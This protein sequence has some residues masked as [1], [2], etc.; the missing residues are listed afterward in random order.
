MA[1]GQPPPSQYPPSMGPGG[2]DRDDDLLSRARQV[3][4]IR[5][6][7]TYERLGEG[8]RLGYEINGQQR[9]YT[10]PYIAMSLPSYYTSDRSI[11][12]TSHFFIDCI[13]GPENVT[14]MV[15]SQQA[16]EAFA[17]HASRYLVWNT[18]GNLTVLAATSIYWSRQR[19]QMK[20]PLRKIK[21]ASRYNQFPN[22][23]LPI[24]KGP[25][26][27][28]LW[29][30]T[31][32]GVLWVCFS[33][34]IDPFTRSAASTSMSVGLMR[35]ERTRLF[36]ETMRDMNKRREPID[37]KHAATRKRLDNQT[38]SRTAGR[39]TS[40]EQDNSA[41]STLPDAA[42]EGYSWS[43][44]PDQQ[45]TDSM[46]DGYSESGVS[47]SYGMGD[48]GDIPPITQQQSRQQQM[49]QRTRGRP[50][51]A[52]PQPTPANAAYS[53]PSASSEDPFAFNSDPSSDPNSPQY[54]P[55]ASSG[56][57][58]QPRQRSWA[59]IRQEARRDTQPD[60]SNSAD[61]YSASS[62]SMRSGTRNTSAANES[63]TS[64]EKEAQK[65]YAQRD[66]AQK[67]FDALLER[68]R[69]LGQAGDSATSGVGKKGWW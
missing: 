47:Y 22:R 9:T 63:Y 43:T 1:S 49:Q 37:S 14:G 21:D 50:P 60:N 45:P 57:Q 15:P 58:S 3:T 20:F 32:F 6:H 11:R 64:G 12:K 7:Y 16:A 51:P 39:S 54:N 17:T 24:I 69:N 36:L 10:I 67:E 66:K 34:L 38:E 25:W 30:C 28:G 55:N 26:A 23:Y 5:S 62:Q 42:S 48:T 2:R 53:S 33:L 29:Q 19:E 18:F 35:D 27:R 4:E 44:S 8:L 31:R 40:Y 41:Q 46:T 68:E 13:R 65:G 52:P 56:S 61:T 59:S